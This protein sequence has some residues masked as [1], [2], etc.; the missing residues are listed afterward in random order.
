MIDRVNLAK[1]ILWLLLFFMPVVAFAHSGRM[2]GGL[3]LSIIVGWPAIF[4]AIHCL[5]VLFL[6]WKTFFR[7]SWLVTISKLITVL[8]S[9]LLGVS[10]FMY[11]ITLIDTMMGNND[12]YLEHIWELLVLLLVILTNLWMIKWAFKTPR[13]QYVEL[14]ENKQKD[15]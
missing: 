2:P 10:A 15:K 11:A 5:I 12:Y 7:Y 1:Q 4:S 8:T 14:T 9:V 13:E 6:R 3:I